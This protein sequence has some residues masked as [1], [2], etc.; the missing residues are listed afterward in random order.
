MENSEKSLLFS[1]KSIT[2]TPPQLYSDFFQGV[3][4]RTHV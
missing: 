1:G 4:P 3:E 2:L